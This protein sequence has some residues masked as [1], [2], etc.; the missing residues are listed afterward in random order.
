VSDLAWIIGSPPLMQAQALGGAHF[1]ID[2]EWCDAQWRLHLDWL[3][4]LDAYP[5]VLHDWLGAHSEKFLGKRFEVLLWFWFEQSPYFQLEI[6]SAQLKSGLNTTGEID[7][8]VLDI[9]NQQWLHLE[10]ACK[11]YL[12]ATKSSQWTQ[13]IGP[14]AHDTLD[15]KMRK[16]CKQLDFGSSEEVRVFLQE[17][18]LE[19][20]RSMGFL[21]GYFFHHFSMVGRGVSPEHVHPHYAS[22]WYASADELGVFGSDL[23]QWLIL[24]KEYWMSPYCSRQLVGDLLSGNEMVAHFQNSKLLK[25]QLVFQVQHVEGWWTEL[26]RGFVVPS[27]WPSLR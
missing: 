8:V 4:D 11:Y 16:L 15:L 26:S 18:Q 10:V 23:A 1:L 9:I 6:H 14:N 19:T 7:F 25:G 22:G 17:K 24:P 13:W 12:G 5:K 3:K 21:K 27:A 20:P 2:E